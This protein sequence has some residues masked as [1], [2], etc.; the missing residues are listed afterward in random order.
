MSHREYRS[1]D[2]NFKNEGQKT[3]PRLDELQYEI[4]NEFGFQKIA[5]EDGRVTKKKENPKM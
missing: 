4:A 5:K 1:T 3:T 2:P